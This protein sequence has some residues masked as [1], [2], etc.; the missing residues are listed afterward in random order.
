MPILYILGIIFGAGAILWLLEFLFKIASIVIVALI[1]GFLVYYVSKGGEFAMNNKTIAGII[2]GFVIYILLL[3]I[4]NFPIFEY[5]EGWWIFSSIKKVGLF[6]FL[7]RAGFSQEFIHL[8]LLT[9]SFFLGFSFRERVLE[10][11]SPE[12]KQIESNKSKSKEIG[13]PKD[14]ES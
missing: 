14:F 11:L 1:I 12:R 2:T 6:E 10:I 3:I 7:R 8:F 4:F 9:I 5:K 13:K